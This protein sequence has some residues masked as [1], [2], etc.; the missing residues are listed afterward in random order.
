MDNLIKRTIVIL[1]EF[2]ED[3]FFFTVEEDWSHWDGVV[4][5]SNQITPEEQ[6]AIC[7][8]L[9]HPVSGEFQFNKLEKFPTEFFREDPE[10]TKVIQITFPM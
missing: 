6:D 8:T 7:D 9:Y 3:L 2:P 4:I 1:A 10:H 5:N